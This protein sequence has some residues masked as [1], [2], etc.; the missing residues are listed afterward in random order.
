MQGGCI[1]KGRRTVGLL[2]AFSLVQL[3]VQTGVPD[4]LYQ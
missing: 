2:L 3:L 4:V 1:I